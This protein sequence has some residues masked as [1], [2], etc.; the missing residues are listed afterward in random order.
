M[1]IHA[2]TPF[3]VAQYRTPIV[4]GEKY[5][6]ILMLVKAGAPRH[7]TTSSAVS[8]VQYKLSMPQC[9]ERQ[10][11]ATKW[12]CEQFQTDNTD[13]TDLQRRLFHPFVW[14]P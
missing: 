13:H 6:H 5:V 2:N 12:K 14:I 1:L 4:V 7:L 11:V 3:L 10:E 8:V 9:Q